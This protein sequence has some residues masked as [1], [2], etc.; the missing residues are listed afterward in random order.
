MSEEKKPFTVSD[1]RHFTSEGEVRRSDSD[2]AAATRT[3]EG[4][5][6]A[7]TAPAA[8][9]SEPSPPRAASEAA[10]LHPPSAPPLA[11]DDDRGARYPADF[12]GLLISLGAQA[13]TL[14]MGGGPEE[15]PD[16]ESARAL[17]EL[18]GVLKEKTEG[19]RTP[20]EDQLLD[21]LLYELRMAYVQAM[22]AGGR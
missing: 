17:I 18:L 12:I 14:L 11:D 21:G 15:P 4:I 19:R 7:S 10:D 22:K 3:E 13:S 20:P 16:T 8:A 6:G 9:V 1:R 2:E 5:S